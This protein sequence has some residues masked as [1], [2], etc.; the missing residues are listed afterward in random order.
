MKQEMS[1]SP[2]GFFNISSASMMVLQ[3]SKEQGISSDCQPPLL[4]QHLAQIGWVATGD[5]KQSYQTG[6][7]RSHRVHT[8][9]PLNA[10]CLGGSNS[11]PSRTATP[12]SQL[13]HK[14]EGPE[15]L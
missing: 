8:S 13:K 5:G 2:K 10:A 15:N 1:W 7:R 9:T 12:S 11:A 14:S 6:W 4:W 3:V